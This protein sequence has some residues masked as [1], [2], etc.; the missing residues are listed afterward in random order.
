MTEII[1]RDIGI[2]DAGW[3]IQRHGELY[4]RDDG[5]DWTFE[6][7]VAEIL[8]DFLRNRDA[9]IERAWIAEKDGMRLGSVFCVRLNDTTAKVRLFLIEPEA[10]GLGLGRT[11]LTACL[12]HARSHGFQRLTLWTHKSHEAACALYS[13]YGFEMI[14]EKPVHS[15]G[16]DLIEQTWSID[17]TA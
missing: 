7:L 11:L 5:F 16:Q 1:L 6:V 3:L 4:A 14:E 13:K 17:L 9:P 8:T 12:A 2:G 15:F 10:R